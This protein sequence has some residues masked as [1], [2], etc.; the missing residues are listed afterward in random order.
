MRNGCDSF[1]S[2]VGVRRSAVK[3]KYLNEEKLKHFK[4]VGVSVLELQ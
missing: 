4:S 1:C 2:F 3:A